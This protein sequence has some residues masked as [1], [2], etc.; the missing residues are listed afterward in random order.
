MVPTSWT[1]PILVNANQYQSTVSSQ[2]FSTILDY[3]LMKIY[4]EKVRFFVW[5]KH[6]IPASIRVALASPN[7]IQYAIIQ[8]LFYPGVGL[9]LA[10]LR[11]HPDTFTSKTNV[12]VTHLGVVDVPAHY[13]LVGYARQI[14]FPIAPAKNI[15][16]CLDYDSTTERTLVP[17][18]HGILVGYRQLLNQQCVVPC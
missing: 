7:D 6:H 9:D 4:R 11:M 12:T 15:K 18:F 14:Q 2:H 16:V 17:N 1:R 3:H 8:L 5:K 13:L 10:E